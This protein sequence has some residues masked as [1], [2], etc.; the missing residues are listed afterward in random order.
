MLNYYQ[1]LGVPSNATPEDIKKAFRRRAKEL[2]PDIQ[3]SSDRLAFQQ[4]VEAYRILS[5]P[6]SRKQYDLY[7]TLFSS[8]SHSYPGYDAFAPLDWLSHVLNDFTP[9]KFYASLKHSITQRITGKIR[10]DFFG[11]KHIELPV[12]FTFPLHTTDMVRKSPQRE[13]LTFGNGFFRISVINDAIHYY[14]EAI[15]E[16]GKN[17]FEKAEE[18][19][20]QAIHIHPTFILPYLSLGNVYRVRGDIERAKEYYRKVQKLD[21]TGLPG[22]LAAHYLQTLPSSK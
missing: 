12:F 15:D 6:Y 2:H 20:K 9:F 4:V 16:L 18:L 1:I 10:V 7:S 21:S 3:P 17:A 22:H 5:E 19:L 14:L 11:M 8:V 13:W